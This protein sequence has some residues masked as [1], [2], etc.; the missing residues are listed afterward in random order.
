MQAEILSKVER[1]IRSR[2]G[3]DRIVLKHTADPEMAEV[4][5][6]DEFVGTVYRDDDDGEVSFDFNMSILDA[7]LE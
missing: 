5:I 4:Y 7:D 3:S 1:C 6:G 2:L